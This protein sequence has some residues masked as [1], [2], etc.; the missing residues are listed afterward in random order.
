[1]YDIKIIFSDRSDKIMCKFCENSKIISEHYTEYSH[2]F[3]KRTVILDNCKTMSV[4]FEEMN[5]LKF[6]NGMSEIKILYCPM[7]GRKL[8]ET[9]D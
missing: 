9:E 1:M 4:K 3:I 5:P 7:C 8:S 2:S 6:L